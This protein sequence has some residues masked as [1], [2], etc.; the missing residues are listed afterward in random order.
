M[1]SKA[2]KHSDGYLL[3]AKQIQ[4]I[5]RLHYEPYQYS[6]HK[7]VWKKYIYPVYVS[8]Y[9]TFLRYLKADTSGVSDNSA[10]ASLKK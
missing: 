8:N 10:T 1:K 3:R 5:D 2:N 4:E 6:C 9:R 7:M